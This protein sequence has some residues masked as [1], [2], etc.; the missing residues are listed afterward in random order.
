MAG[1]AWLVST[2]WTQVLLWF[3]RRQKTASPAPD[4]VPM[5]DKGMEAP[6]LAALAAKAG[7]TPSWLPLLEAVL[8]AV[9]VLFTAAL[10][11]LL[12]YHLARWCCAL[13]KRFRSW[14]DDEKIFLKPSLLHTDPHKN[15]KHAETARR[16]RMF[17]PTG[18]CRDAI[19]RHYRRT[20]RSCLKKQK[21]QPEPWASPKELEAAAHCSSHTF[22]QL[23]EKARYSQNEC[24]REDLEAIIRE[25]V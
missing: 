12:L 1:G 16:F 5:P 20:V 22:H 21:L 17:H 24:T 2:V 19:R 11:F 14:D 9:E 18:S 10:L 3:S 8:A 13:L 6:D 15:K 25:T 4:F 23:Y 7:K